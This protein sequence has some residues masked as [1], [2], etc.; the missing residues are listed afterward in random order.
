LKS[1]A[2]YSNRTKNSTKTDF[3]FT[4]ENISYLS[5]VYLFILSVRP[6]LC[7]KFKIYVLGFLTSSGVPLRMNML[8]DKKCIINHNSCGILHFICKMR[9]NLQL[10]STDGV[11]AISAVFC[12]VIPVEQKI[13]LASS[14]HLDA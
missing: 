14:L 12:E 6:V 4:S 3:L 11:R 8:I 1:V 7:E 9:Q 5:S 10:S 13:S 2:F